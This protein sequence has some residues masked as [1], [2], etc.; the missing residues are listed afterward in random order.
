MMELG[1]T[2]SETATR[3]ATYLSTF[4]LKRSCLFAFAL[5]TVLKTLNES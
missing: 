3:N 5:K 1:A 2:E 4:R